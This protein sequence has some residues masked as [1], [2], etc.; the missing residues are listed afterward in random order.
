MHNGRRETKLRG[1]LSPFRSSLIALAIGAPIALLSPAHAADPLPPTNAEVVVRVHERVV[2][3]LSLGRGEQS[4][5]DRARLASEALASVVDR[6]DPPD[7]RVEERDGVAVVFFGKTP[8]IT[9]ADEDAAASGETLH[10]YAAAIAARAQEGVRA[11]ET[12]STIAN[13]VFSISLLVFSGLLALLLFRRIGAFAARATA[14][15]KENPQ[16]I[17]A[18]RLRHIEVIRPRAVRGGVTVALSLSHLVT[19]VAIVYGWLLFALS[20]FAVTR[21]YTERLSGFVL[22][23]LWALIG[24]LGSALPIVV[25]ASLAAFA[26]GILVRFT[27]LFFESV[28][29]GGTWVG[30]LPQNL[31]KPASVLARAGII[32]IALV[33]AAPLLTGAD[34]GAL[35]RIGVVV[36]AALGLSATPVL[37]C[38]V[39]GIPVIFGRTV[40]VG[41]IVAIGD[42]AGSVKEVSLLGVTLLARDGSELRIPHLIGLVCPTRVIGPLSRVSFDVAID[43]RESQ[44]RV[45]ELLLALATPLMTRAKIEMVSLDVDAARYRLTGVRMEGA[46]DLESAVADALRAENVTLG[47]ARQERPS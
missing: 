19:Q 6:G 36:L 39:A 18:L 4:S 23:P 41:D 40:S 37:A 20:L 35:S 9:L 13:T 14:W 25:V 15:V 47:R 27:G 7:A 43:P 12:R 22:A 3:P 33:L 24:R 16:R 2:F 45:R 44:A 38:V 26:V 31:A 21:P 5:Q 32:V 17:P 1:V 11:E 10:V 29:E 46:G 28:A 30:W 34:D 8:I 42:S